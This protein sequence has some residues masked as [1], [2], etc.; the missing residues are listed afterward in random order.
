MLTIWDPDTRALTLAKNSHQPAMLSAAQWWKVGI[1]M[2]LV[3]LLARAFI[4]AHHSST[5]LPTQTEQRHTSPHGDNTSPARFNHWIQEV[6]DLYVLLY[7][8][9]HERDTHITTWRA[10]RSMQECQLRE[11]TA[12]DE[13]DARPVTVSNRLAPNETWCAVVKKLLISVYLCVYSNSVG[14]WDV[15]QA[16]RS[17]R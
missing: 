7:W 12:D 2:L 1:C 13:M 11:Q 9:T 17:E 14:R 8:L 10:N 3:L 5:L 4:L 16:G 6:A 15:T